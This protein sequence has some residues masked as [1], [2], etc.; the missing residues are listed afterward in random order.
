MKESAGCRTLRVGS[1][2]AGRAGLR[3]RRQPRQPP[4]NKTAPGSN[5]TSQETQQEGAER[6]EIIQV[7]EVPGALDHLQTRPR[8]QLAHDLC[9]GERRLTVLFAPDQQR[10][11]EDE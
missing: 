9:I 5:P 10:G 7:A 4:E 3:S 11:A 8:D 6:R 2:A 1:S